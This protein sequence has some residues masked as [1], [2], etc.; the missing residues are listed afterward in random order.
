M[1]SC[2]TCCIHTRP[3][4]TR[5]SCAHARR[6]SSANA[7]CFFAFH[8]PVAMRAAYSELYLMQIGRPRARPFEWA[9]CSARVKA[10]RC[11]KFWVVVLTFGVV[12]LAIYP[13]ILK[14]SP[15]PPPWVATAP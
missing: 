6:A 14:I 8:A 1:S 5:L 3:P 2:H 11:A 9:H 7:L 15:T 13:P 12:P 10:T 4:L